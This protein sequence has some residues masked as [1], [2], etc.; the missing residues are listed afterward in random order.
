MDEV[1]VDSEK[2]G[3]KDS[4]DYIPYFLNSDRKSD[5]QSIR[6]LNF[7]FCTKNFDFLLE[8]KKN[9]ITGRKAKNSKEKGLHNKYTSDNMIKK[10]KTVILRILGNLI[11]KKIKNIFHSNQKRLLKMN[12]KQIINTHVNYNKLFL[13]KKLKDIFSENVSSKCKRYPNDY[14]RR[15][16]NELL[17]QKDKN[18][19]I[20]FSDLLNLTFLDC[21]EH[22]SG[23]KQI[24]CLQ[25]LENI[26]DVCKSLGDDK[27]YQE[28]FRCYIENF[29]TIIEK[30]KPRGKSKS[31][32]LINN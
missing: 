24:Y 15:L 9:K 31:K 6:L 32:I 18:K 13:Y 26:D 2:N 19:K 7:S 20:F 14:N 25:D 29:Q 5:N 23:L 27:N 30:K 12:Q 28:S 22:F 11:N 16:I 17:N 4:V 1:S 8:K 21:V 3:L 10:C